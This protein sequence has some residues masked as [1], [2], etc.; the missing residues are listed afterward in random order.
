MRR[1]I[2]NFARDT[3]GQDLIEYALLAGF[4]SLASVTM[5]LNVGNGVGAIW[6]EVDT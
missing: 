3:P 2:A 5:I 4:I 6:H 1:F